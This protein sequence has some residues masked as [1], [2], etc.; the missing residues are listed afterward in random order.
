MLSQT[1]LMVLVAALVAS[2]VLIGTL[3]FVLA[4]ASAETKRLLAAF[5]AHAFHLETQGGVLAEQVEAGRAQIASLDTNR[6]DLDL[7]ALEESALMEAEAARERLKNVLDSTAEMYVTLDLDWRLTY[8]N[9]PGE[10]LIG[11]RSQDLIGRRMWDL[12]PEQIGNAIYQSLQKAMAE[13]ARV[14]VEW[15]NAVVDQ[16]FIVHAYPTREGLALHYEDVTEAKRAG[17]LR[18][19]LASIVESSDDA[20]ISMDIDGTVQSWNDGAESLYGY[21]A[22]EAIGCSLAML[23]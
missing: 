23:V 17:E 1:L 18:V 5:Q 22:D 6:D 13:R 16:S 11:R 9:K 20:I 15:Y 8:V 2:G 21:T 7:D 3:A 4:R 10:Q 19:R 12:F 14:Q